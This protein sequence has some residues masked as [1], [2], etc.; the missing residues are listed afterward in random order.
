MSLAA[1]LFRSQ[2]TFTA[3]RKQ[4]DGNGR[5]ETY[6]QLGSFSCTWTNKPATVKTSDG[7]EFTPSISIYTKTADIQRGDVIAIGSFTDLEPVDSAREVM[8]IRTDQPMLGTPDYN[9]YAD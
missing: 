8:D 6:L 4:R 7:R 5:D 2:S 9:I 3:W 1:D